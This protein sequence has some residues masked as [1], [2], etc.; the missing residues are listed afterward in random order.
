[1]K[2]KDYSL[3]RPQML[4][5]KSRIIKGKRIVATLS[6]YLGKDQIKHSKALDVGS[7]TGIIDSFLASKFK[8]VW[9]IDIDQNGVNFAKKNFKH[10][11][12][13]FLKVSA[14][15][16]PFQNNSFDIVICTHVYEHVNNPNKLL[17]EIYRVLKPNG[18][19]YFAAINA[20]WPIEPHH[21]LLFLSYLPKDIANIYIKIFTHKK[22]YYENPLFLWQL[23]KLVSKFEIVDYTAKIL[24]TPHKFGY[25]NPSIPRFLAKILKYFTPT[26]FW[27]L[28]KNG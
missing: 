25:K 18:V 12:L 13:H 19:C 22:V 1:M 26:V 10:R 8:D 23:K 17:S 20:I 6:D 15:N 21:N 7:S 28:I 3:E 4:D 9:G 27:L 16:I 11:N 14:E 5:I 24:E 2:Q